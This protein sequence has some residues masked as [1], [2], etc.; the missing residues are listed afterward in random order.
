MGEC[1]QMSKQQT[2]SLIRVRNGISGS[3]VLR[4]S[5]HAE[6]RKH[7][8]FVRSDMDLKYIEFINLQGSA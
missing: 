5:D 4:F 1:E 2:G 3:A 7:R 8:G 6:H